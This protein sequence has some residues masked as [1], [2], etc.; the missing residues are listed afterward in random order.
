MAKEK[1]LQKFEGKNPTLWE[2]RVGHPPKKCF[3]QGLKPGSTNAFMSE[4][5]L[6]PPKQQTKSIP[7]PSAAKADLKI[8]LSSAGLKSSSPC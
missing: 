3:P 7:L 2:A 8:E 1:Y 5:K 4:L 6:R